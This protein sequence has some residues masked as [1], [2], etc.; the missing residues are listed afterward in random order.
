MRWHEKLTQKMV[1]SCLPFFKGHLGVLKDVTMV[2]LGYEFVIA[3]VLSIWPEL[4][5]LYEG[6]QP[7]PLQSADK[8]ATPSD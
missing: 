5:S 8:V 1:F 7:E 2:S 4:V 6:Y 3:I